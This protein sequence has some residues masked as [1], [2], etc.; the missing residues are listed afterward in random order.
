MTELQQVI[1]H[2]T[3]HDH[4][5]WVALAFLNPTLNLRLKRGFEQRVDGL[6][7][8]ATSAFPI[9]S[10]PKPKPSA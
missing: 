9:C 4:K 5:L 10:R 3:A 8:L 6:D 2:P 7:N 1:G